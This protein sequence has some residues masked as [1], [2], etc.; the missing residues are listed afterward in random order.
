MS[1]NPLKYLSSKDERYFL[2]SDNM[3]NVETAQKGI[4]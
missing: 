4:S 3:S 2:W 1:L